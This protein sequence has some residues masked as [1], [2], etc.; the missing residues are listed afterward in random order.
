M[1]E[2]YKQKLTQE[3][4]SFLCPCLDLNCNFPVCLFLCFVCMDAVR[5]EVRGSA[6]EL[7]LSF[8]YVGSDLTSSHLAA[9]TFTPGPSHWYLNPNS[10]VPTLGGRCCKFHHLSSTQGD[11]GVQELKHA[12]QDHTAQDQ[13]QTSLLSPYCTDEVG[14]LISSTSAFSFF[15]KW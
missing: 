4:P 8:Y 6:V 14:D 13:Q 7:V 3:N 5:V 12:Y 1:K 11:L 2:K 9:S 10:S 15:P